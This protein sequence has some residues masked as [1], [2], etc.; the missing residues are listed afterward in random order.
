MVIRPDLTYNVI[1]LV[2]FI[3]NP[4][5]EHISIV[6]NIFRYLNKTKDLSIIYTK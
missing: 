1:L 5:K 4:N 6:N 2:R 3:I